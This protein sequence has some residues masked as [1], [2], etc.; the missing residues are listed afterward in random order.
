MPAK[1]VRFSGRVQ[2]VGFR[3]RTH[4][5]AAGFAVGGYVRNLGDGRVELRAEGEAAEIER[6]LTAVR[7]KLSGHIQGEEIEDAAPLGLPAFEIKR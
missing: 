2:G 4:E 3:W 1:L 6:F 5:L 7:A